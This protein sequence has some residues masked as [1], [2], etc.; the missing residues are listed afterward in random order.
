MKLRAEKASEI[1]PHAV[2]SNAVACACVSSRGRRPVNPVATA[3]GSELLLTPIGWHRQETTFGEAS[4][5]H[6][7]RVSQNRER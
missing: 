1:S 3:L 7:G 4:F 6:V 2:K 5:R